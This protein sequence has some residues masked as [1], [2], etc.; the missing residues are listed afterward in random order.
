MTSRE[1]SMAN[2]T[3]W[4]VALSLAWIPLGPAAAAEVCGLQVPASM[5]MDG[6]RISLLSA[7]GQH[8]VSINDHR[9]L[10][11]G[12][13]EALSPRQAELLIRLDARWRQ[14]PGDLARIENSAAAQALNTLDQAL[15]QRHLLS[16]A[17]A[18]TQ[19]RPATVTPPQRVDF[20]TWARDS[21]QRLDQAVSQAV[22]QAASQV[23]SSAAQAASTAARQSAMPVAL[24]NG[25][26]MAP[27]ASLPLR[28][29]HETRSALTEARH[30]LC[31]D[32]QAA[33][34]LE[35]AIGRFD[36]LQPQKPAI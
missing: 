24:Q 17:S 4:L 20:S 22:S 34:A 10:I 29:A 5:Q 13:A 35:G 25:D 14:I 12:R 23:A 11:D 33:D 7:S 32:L 27:T 8:Q 1:M 18:A 9:L 31:T 15:Q 19:A 16:A 6:H 3:V 36:L 30:Q 21:K 28:H 2:K 26:D